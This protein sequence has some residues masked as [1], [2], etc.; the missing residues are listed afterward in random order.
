[1][2]QEEFITNTATGKSLRFYKS[3]LFEVRLFPNNSCGLPEIYNIAIE[4]SANDPALLVFAHDDLHVLDFHWYTRLTQAI[5]SFQI[6]GLAG[7]KHLEPRQKTWWFDE[8][9]RCYSHDK[10]SGVVAHGTGYPPDGITFYGP[11]PQQV[12]LLDGL[13][14]ACHSA[15]M[16]DAGLRFDER[17]DFHFY[18]MDLCRQ[19]ALM[20]ITMG[21]CE[22]SVVHESVGNIPSESW[23]QGY[24]LYMDKWKE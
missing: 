20:N 10:L 11:V 15:T 12:E 23:A 14:L 22:L 8:Q 4:E 18:D 9:F 13:L 24:D 1:V 16:I 2:P 21:T 19:A 7:K 5:Q 6:V 3:P 17:F